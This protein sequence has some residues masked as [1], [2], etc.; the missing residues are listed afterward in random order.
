[1]VSRQGNRLTQYNNFQKLA[2]KTGRERCSE[3]DL[4][5]ERSR[6]TKRERGGGETDKQTN[7]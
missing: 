2:S 7:H 1:M 3:A 6:G 4:E 5:K